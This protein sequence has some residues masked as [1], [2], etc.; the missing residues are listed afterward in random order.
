MSTWERLK[1]AMRTGRKILKVDTWRTPPKAPPHQPK[2]YSFIIGKNY[3]I[4]D[5][6][7][8]TPTKTEMC[9][10][11]GRFCVFRYEGKTGIH[12]VFREAR[13]GWQRTYTDAQ[14]IGKKIEEAEA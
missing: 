9:P 3:T 6:K 5:N 1:E 12:H 7:I 11:S 8:G 14:L 10:C 13:G 2:Q 4:R